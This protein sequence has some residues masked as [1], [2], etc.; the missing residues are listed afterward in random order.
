MMPASFSRSIR[1]ADA[2]STYLDDNLFWL[3][4][5]IS[6]PLSAFRMN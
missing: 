5:Q 2:S 6:N 3:K 4:N 1:A